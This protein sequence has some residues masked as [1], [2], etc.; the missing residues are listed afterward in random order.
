MYINILDHAIV[1]VE[2]F[3][4]IY[5]DPKEYCLCLV[6]LKGTHVIKTYDPSNNNH[7][8]DMRAINGYMTD[9]E[10]ILPFP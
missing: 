4:Y 1:S 10:L 8:E 7:I 3:K 6:T 5:Y 9:Y 2:E